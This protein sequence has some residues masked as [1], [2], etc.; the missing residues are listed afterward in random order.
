MEVVEEDVVGGKAGE[1]VQ[2]PAEHGGILLPDEPPDVEVAG[3]RH[4]GGLEDQQ[5]G[6]QIGHRLAGE[7]QRQP[8]EGAEQ[9]IKAVGGDEVHPE[10]GVAVPEHA[11]LP[12]GVVGQ[13]VEGDLL[14]IEVP[15]EEKVPLFIDH[16]RGEHQR[17]RQ[18]RQQ[19]HPGPAGQPPGAGDRCGVGRWLHRASLDMSSK[20]MTA[21]SGAKNSISIPHSA[22]RFHK[23]AAGRSPFYKSV[24][25]SG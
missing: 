10:V 13:P 15:E 11:P 5:R 4:A 21:P 3:Q 8:E 19:K 20:R 24:V 6:H 14:D 25:E 16:D 12:D 18:Q 23:R 2:Q 17:R 7:W 9:Q 1:G 22:P